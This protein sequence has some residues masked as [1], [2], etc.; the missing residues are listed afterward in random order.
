MAFS[1]LIG[2]F[3]FWCAYSADFRFLWGMIFK[4]ISFLLFALA[5]SEPVTGI[6]KTAGQ[7]KEASDIDSVNQI[8]KVTFG[9]NTWKE[10]DGADETNA[11]TDVK[12]H[13]VMDHSVRSAKR[14]ETTW[15]RPRHKT[16]N[17]TYFRMVVDQTIKELADIVE[18]YKRAGSGADSR[19]KRD[20]GGGGA[21][22]KVSG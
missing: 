13:R 10:F 15:Y 21:D 19:S 4:F 5:S 7:T 11:Q 18:E 8:Q 20:G 2:D 22:E 3:G 1:T 6:L 12:Y 14:K 9:R 17:A 16:D